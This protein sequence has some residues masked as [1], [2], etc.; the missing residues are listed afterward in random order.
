MRRA[1]PLLLVALAAPAAA[2]PPRGLDPIELDR[3]LAAKAPAFEECVTRARQ[4]YPEA[5]GRVVIRFET[6]A[7]GR[8]TDVQID[9]ATTANDSIARCYADKFWTFGFTPPGNPV[10]TAVEFEVPPPAR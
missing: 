2:G 4:C 9:A 3:Q 6:D 8:V 5:A 1:L 10:E 7:S